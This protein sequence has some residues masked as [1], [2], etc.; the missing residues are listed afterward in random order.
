[1]CCLHV[2]RYSQVGARISP[3]FRQHSMS[4]L[5]ICCRQ[6]AP[7]LD[8]KALGRPTCQPMNAATSYLRDD[9]APIPCR[10]ALR[11]LSASLAQEAHL[12]PGMSDPAE[13]GS[14][15]QVQWQQGVRSASCKPG[16]LLRTCTG[17]TAHTRTHPLT[18][19]ATKSTNSWSPPAN[20]PYVTR[21]TCRAQERT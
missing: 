1:M 10:S 9:V 13:R 14:E 12:P 7:E 19:S 17:N 8:C 11:C 21:S 3:S 2:P 15:A 18:W 4:S 6:T 16:C 20:S 5:P